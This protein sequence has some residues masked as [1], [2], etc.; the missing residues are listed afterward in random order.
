MLDPGLALSRHGI[1]ERFAEFDVLAAAG[2]G[3]FYEHATLYR[4]PPELNGDITGR[5]NGL[6]YL[7]LLFCRRFPDLIIVAVIRIPVVP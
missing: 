1:R 6:R 4:F 3:E 5:G 2:R 7:F